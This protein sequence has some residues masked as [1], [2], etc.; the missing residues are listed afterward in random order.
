MV[1]MLLDD[2]VSYEAATS[3]DVATFDYTRY[4]KRKQWHLKAKASSKADCFNHDTAAACNVA[5]A[6]LKDVDI[7]EYQV[8][9]DEAMTSESKSKQQ[10]R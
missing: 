1:L 5:A 4:W 7:F 9:E 10:S 2:V 3:Y 6:A 8:L